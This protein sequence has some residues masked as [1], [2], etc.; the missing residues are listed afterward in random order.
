[1]PPAGTDVVSGG[2]EVLGSSDVEG[3]EGV[4]EVVVD[5]LPDVDEL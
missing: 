3:V 4:V 1:V 5:E 2:V